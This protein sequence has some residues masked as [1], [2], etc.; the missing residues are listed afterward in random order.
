MR[1]ALLLFTSLLLLPSVAVSQIP[2]GALRGVV[3]DARGGRIPSAKI[4]VRAAESSFEHEAS[5]DERGEFR[6]EN[7]FPGTYHVVVSARGFGEA[8]SHV[9]VAVSS[10]R[11][12]TVT[13]L[14][15]TIQESVKV[16]A[17]AS[18]ITTQPID[19][20]SAVHQAVITTQDLE[21]IPL[22]ARSFANI[23]YLAPGTEPVEPSDPTKARITAVSTGGSSGLNNEVSVDGVDNSDDWI[24]GF[25]Q[26]FSPENIQEF[27][28]RTAQEDADTGRTTAGSVVITTKHGTNA[29]HGDEGF[30]ERAA[31]L[32]ARFPIENPAP[33]PKQPFSRQNYIGTLGGPLV[34]DKLWFY[35]SLEYV[36]ENA[37]IAYSP[38]S[39]AQFQALSQLAAQGRVDVSGTTVTSIPVPSSVTIPFRDYL[40]SVRFDWQQSNRSL[41]FLRA[42]ADSYVTRNALIQQATLPSTGATTHNNYGNLAISNQFQFGSNWLGSFVFGASLLHLTQLRNSDLGF[43]LA[44][45]F[46]TTSNTTSGLE[47]FGDNQFVTAITAFPV[48]RNQEKYQWRYDVTHSAGRHVPQ[49]GINFIH[50]PVLS[51]ALT[52]NAET[53]ALF[54]LNP[55]DYAANP[56]QFSTDLTQ[57]TVTANANVTPG[58]MCQVTPAGDGSFSQNVQ[59]LGLYAQDSWR[60]TPR[61]TLNYGLR[62]DTTFGLF[63]AS[64]HEQ[65]LN[66][67]LAGNGVVTGIPHDYRKAF[68]PRLALAYGLGA[69]GSTVVR[70]G[71]GLYYNDLAQ[72]GWVEAFNAVNNFNIQNAS[73]PSSLIDPNYKT[74]YALH[75]TVGVQ[76]AFNADWNLSADW[77][78]ETGMHG[79]RRYDYPGGISVFRSDNRSS[80][81]ALAI[82]LQGNVAR[83]LN[84]VANYTLASAKTWGCVLGELFDYVNGVCDPLNAFASGDYGPSGEDV[85]QRFLL[86]GTLRLPAGF[87]VTTLTQAES[88]R[89]FTITTADN[90]ARIS[91]NGV[92]TSLD[93]FRGT[94]YI[95]ADLRVSRPFRIHERWSVLPFIEFFNLFNRNNPGANYVANVAALPVPAAEAQSGNVMNICLDAACTSTKP[96][97]RLSQ[98]AVPAG[99]LGD[100]FG[101]GTTVGIPFAAQLGV[102]LSF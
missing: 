82:H 25:L 36:H 86:A 92:P 91:V 8:S 72:N 19:T 55:M 65:S 18:S 38:A 41:W 93:E 6:I 67:A 83:R 95:Q 64:G 81:K 88:A 17:E 80:Y 98:L 40:S 96:V 75:T 73:G 44:F 9:K 50:E 58:T 14:P 29:W 33:N 35:S 37:S 23:A 24:G 59:R 48:L 46:S 62:Y 11:E 85:R 10:A 47:T 70:A 74:P 5:A 28:I 61:L 66:P 26:N 79:Y 27:A 15:Q 32:N 49:F 39:Q 89:P 78:L 21:T 30:Y 94:P 68:A 31:A 69:S 63:I 43:A 51:G 34:K 60:V 99:G 77:T 101:P 84:L 42:S 3:Q 13:L 100:F 1:T 71:I 87:E 12:M 22:A 97:T 45:P 53:L 2:R 102:K 16:Q 90:S 57:C 56:Q 4:V 7:L 76:H 52:A 54:V 20:A